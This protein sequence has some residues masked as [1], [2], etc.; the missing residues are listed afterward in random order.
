[1]VCQIFTVAAVEKSEGK[2]PEPDKRAYAPNSRANVTGLWKFTMLEW[3]FN[4]QAD[5][6]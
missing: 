2:S 1:M 5:Q 3:C 6:G 4:D